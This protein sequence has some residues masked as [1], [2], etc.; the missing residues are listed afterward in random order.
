MPKLG[1]HTSTKETDSGKQL[2]GNKDLQYLEQVSRQAV[3]E[4]N[5]FSVLYFELDW[6]LSKK[7]FYGE[8][9]VKKFK[10]IK[11]VP[12]KVK[13]KIKEGEETVF[14][15]IPS[16]LL[17]LDLAIYTEQLKE[18]NIDP[19]LDDFFALGQRLYR[20]HTRSI[21]DSGVSGN[22]MVNRK[23]MEMKYF[24]IQEDDEN[25]QKDVWGENLGLEYQINSYNGDLLKS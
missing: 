24:C 11:G 6:E 22:V 9:L 12:V 25:L 2:L 18:L 23:R 4:H 17:Q 3:E 7:N 21:N 15:N 5:N 10:T 14:N 8:L 1:G 13:L 19:K 20:I 16:Q